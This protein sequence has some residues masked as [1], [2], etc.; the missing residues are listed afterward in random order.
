MVI[1]KL[2]FSDYKLVFDLELNI[3]QIEIFEKKKTQTTAKMSKKKKMV[4]PEN[5]KKKKVKVI[6]NMT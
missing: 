1:N 6:P 2:N 5:R 4:L 3:E